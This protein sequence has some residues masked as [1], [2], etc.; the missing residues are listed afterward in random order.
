MKLLFLLFCSQM[1]G[2]IEK[3][4]DLNKFG[5]FNWDSEITKNVNHKKDIADILGSIKA[6]DYLRDISAQSAFLLLS[7]AQ[8]DIVIKNALDALF[9]AATDLER[10]QLQTKIYKGMA[11]FFGKPVAGYLLLVYGLKQA[12]DGIQ[13]AFG[14][15][16]QPYF[17]RWGKHREFLAK[18]NPIKIKQMTKRIVGYDL[19]AR[20]VDAVVA[21]LKE[22]MQSGKKIE[23]DGWLLYGKPG[24]GKTAWVE[25]IAYQTGLP[26]MVVNVNDLINSKSGTIEEN[27][28]LLFKELRRKSPC[29]CFFDELDL[30][31]QNKPEI[32]GQLLQELDGLQSKKGVFVIAATNEKQVI[33]ESL[34]RPGRLGVHFEVKNP[35][36]DDIRLLV[37][38]YLGEKNITLANDVSYDVFLVSLE[39]FSCAAVKAYC[40]C[41]EKL[42]KKNNTT[43]VIPAFIAEANFIYTK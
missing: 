29:I 22:Q 1:F 7:N 36:L 21:E 8:Q 6:E 18:L 43:V 42:C 33:R 39:G 37:S 25:Y 5:F 27:L 14:Q 9:L 20:Q 38:L 15:F 19:L 40:E 35:S 12:K 17:D 2:K 32:L 16:V 11:I 34:L 23:M 24:N 41:L 28:T 3:I 4:S 30:M 10:K 31:L 26:L 13:Y